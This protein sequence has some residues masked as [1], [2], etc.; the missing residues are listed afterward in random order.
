VS[1][2]PREDYVRCSVTAVGY[3]FEPAVEYR[4]G[5]NFFR[6]LRRLKHFAHDFAHRALDEVQRDWSSFDA[7]PTAYDILDRLPDPMATAREIGKR[8]STEWPDRAYF[9]E[10]WQQGR[11]G[12]AQVFQP[13]GV[14]RNPAG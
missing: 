13:F 7:M 8:I 12:F 5:D 10:V 1:R 2:P 14:P 3:T 9:V 11:E 6:M 4:D